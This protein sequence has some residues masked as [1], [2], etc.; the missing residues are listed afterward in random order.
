MARSAKSKKV[1]QK[2]AGAS[3]LGN[4]VLHQA[5]NLIPQRVQSTE[6]VK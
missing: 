4:S 2:S 5:G 6:Q 3:L 1:S